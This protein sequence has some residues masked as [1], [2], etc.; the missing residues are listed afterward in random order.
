MHANPNLW[1]VSHC[2]RL[3]C[4]PKLNQT[5]SFDLVFDDMQQ[6]PGNCRLSLHY[7]S[8]RSVIFSD[9][10]LWLWNENSF[11]WDEKRSNVAQRER[12][13]NRD[14]MFGNRKK[15]ELYGNQAETTQRELGKCKKRWSGNSVVLDWTKS[16]RSRAE[17]RF[18]PENKIH[19]RA[20]GPDDSAET[21]L[22]T[23]D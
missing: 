7:L 13:R 10:I 18:W 1:M 21:D 8:L 12:E 17:W 6:M 20:T 14:E 5:S 3:E 9:F 2:D 16:S 23:L 11:N 22:R 15:E 19:S 4:D